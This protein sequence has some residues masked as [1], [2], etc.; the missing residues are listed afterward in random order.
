[1]Q[2]VIVIVAIYKTES[3][4]KMFNKVNLHLSTKVLKQTYTSFQFRVGNHFLVRGKGGGREGSFF[5]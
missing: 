5:C 1:M 3:K 4:L 2:T